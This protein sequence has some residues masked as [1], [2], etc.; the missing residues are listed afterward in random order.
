MSRKPGP[1]FKYLEQPIFCLC[2][3][4]DFVLIASGG[5]GKKF[6]VG[7]QIISYKILTNNQFSDVCHFAEFDK[8]IPVFISSFELLNVFSTCVD[9]ITIFYKI[10]ITTGVFDEIFRLQVMDIYDADLY[11]SV[12]MFDNKGALFATGTTDGILK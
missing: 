10:N 8:E 7:N 9:N 11:Q 3:L 4:K 2:T 12:C 6:G 5:G 1:R